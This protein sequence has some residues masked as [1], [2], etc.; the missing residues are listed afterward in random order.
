MILPTGFIGPRSL[1]LTD[2]NFTSTIS[3][4][5]GY[6]MGGILRRSYTDRFSL[7]TGIHY[8]TFMYDLN[9][10]VP[11]SNVSGSNDLKFTTYDIP[12]N[13]LVFVK[14]TEIWH[15]SAA[16]GITALYKPSSV[17]VLSNPEG[18]HLFVQ[19]GAAL[20]KFGLDANAQFGFELRTR[21]KGYFYLGGSA[22]VP[23]T[24]L[25]IFFT[26]YEYEDNSYAAQAN[27][28]GGYFTVDL[29]YYFHNV[30]NKGAQPNQSP[31]D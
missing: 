4:R 20:N 30:K 2:P 15:A 19:T 7:E 6:S 3:S 17:G 21:D 13:A 18:K 24:N 27:Y 14:L 31:I 11:D 28:K 5:N 26:K 25:F 9:A 16:L 12:L 23:L 22:R 8:N 1:T 29:R 10:S